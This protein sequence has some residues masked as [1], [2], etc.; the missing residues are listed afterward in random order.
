MTLMLVYIAQLA[1][2]WL[3][4]GPW[5][6]PQGQNYPQSQGFGDA[7]TMSVLIDGTR[8]TWG[9]VYALVLALVAW[10]SRRKPSP[11]FA[12]RWPGWRL[13]LPPM[14]AFRKSATSGSH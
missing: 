13:P 1:L 7:E 4:H 12:C 3:V 8:V 14:R 5:R 9:I 6:D 2:S 11:V 10:V